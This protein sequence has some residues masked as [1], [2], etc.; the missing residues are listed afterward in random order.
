MPGTL[1]SSG[2][3][4]F[5]GEHRLEPLVRGILTDGCGF[6]VDRLVVR[7]TPDGLCLDGVIRSPRGSD[8]LTDLIRAA[9]GVAEILNRLVVFHEDPPTPAQTETE[10]GCSETW[11]G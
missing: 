10:C 3:N 8:G 5:A 7:R 2:V 1:F 9:T 4:P 6:H 11:Q